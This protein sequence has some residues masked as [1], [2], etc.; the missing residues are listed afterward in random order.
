MT[1][2]KA[3]QQVTAEDPRLTTAKAPDWPQPN[4]HFSWPTSWVAAWKPV[5]ASLSLVPLAIRNEWVAQTWRWPTVIGGFV[6]GG[7]GLVT[8]HD[9]WSNHP[10]RLIKEGQPKAE[11]GSKKLRATLCRLHLLPPVSQSAFQLQ[12]SDI[13]IQLM[14]LRAFMRMRAYTYACS[15]FNV[16]DETV[17]L[18]LSCEGWN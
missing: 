2:A 8:L 15:N 10:P 18:F 7:S 4:P 6:K 12:S 17:F 3:P 13:M 1:T 16:G 9:F 11:I 5:L 14:D